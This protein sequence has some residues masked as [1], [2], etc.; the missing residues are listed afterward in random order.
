MASYIFGQYIPASAFFS[1][2]IIA[3]AWVLISLSLSLSL[4]LNTEPKLQDADYRKG[5]ID[6]AADPGYTRPPAR[7][8]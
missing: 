6:G 1:Q 3:S 2:N 7:G 4:N 5:I 8:H